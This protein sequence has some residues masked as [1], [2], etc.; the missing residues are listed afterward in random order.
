MIDPEHKARVDAA[1]TRAFRVGV[2]VHLPQTEA[3][4]AMC[5]VNPDGDLVIVSNTLIIEDVTIDPRDN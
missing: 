5:D 2:H 4:Y 3:A 1:V